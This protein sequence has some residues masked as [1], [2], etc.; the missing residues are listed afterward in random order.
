MLRVYLLLDV[1]QRI[2]RVNC[3]ADEDN[4]GIGV[5][6]GAETIVILLACR[7]PEG[8]FDMLA[9][10]LYIGDVVFKD[11]W[12]VDLWERELAFGNV[13]GP[14]LGKAVVEREQAGEESGAER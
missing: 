6:E 5:G 8:E 3:E 9:I 4:V 12:D 11:G 1:V 10:N 13:C 14:P 7:I 2:G